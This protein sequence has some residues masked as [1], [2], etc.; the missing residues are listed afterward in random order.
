[1]SNIDKIPV[2]LVWEWR[3]EKVGEDEEEIWLPCLRSVD[4]EEWIANAHKQ[5]LENEAETFGREVMIKVEKVPTNHLYGYEDVGLI[6][7]RMCGLD[8]WKRKKNG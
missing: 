4:R 1:M 2:W 7:E 5:A 3:K 6:R 8:L